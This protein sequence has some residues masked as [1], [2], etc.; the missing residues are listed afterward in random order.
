MIVLHLPELAARRRRTGAALA[1]LRRCGA[2][3]LLCARRAEQ[4]RRLTELD[5]HMLKDIGVSARAAADESRK[6]FWRA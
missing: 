4:R 6:P 3:C 1:A 2:W 5:E